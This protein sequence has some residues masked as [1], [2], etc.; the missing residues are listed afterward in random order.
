MKL[1]IFIN[2]L[3]HKISHV[4]FKRTAFKRKGLN[5]TVGIGCSIKN[6]EYITIGDNSSLGN[7][8]T[9]QTWPNYRGETTNMTPELIIGNEVSFMEHCHISCMNSITIG[10]GCLLGNNVF[11]TDNF[12]GNISKEELNIPPIKR[13]LFSKN[14]VKIG[15]NVWIGRNVCIMPD[16]IIGNGA[17]IAANAVVTKNVPSNAVVAGVPAKIIKIIN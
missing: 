17:I 9:L 1:I 6:P 7:Y 11:I 10:D 13:K 16:V 4:K 8:C 2:H 5:W 12:H 3:V 14:R 15:K